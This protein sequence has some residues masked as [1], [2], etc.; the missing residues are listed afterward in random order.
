MFINTNIKIKMDEN[1]TIEGHFIGI[2][3]DGSMNL[4]QKDTKISIYS[5]QIIL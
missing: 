1:K 3:D 2:N 5:G 4:L